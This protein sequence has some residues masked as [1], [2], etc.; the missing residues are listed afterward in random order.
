VEVKQYSI[1]RGTGSLYVTV[2]SSYLQTTLT[3]LSPGTD[4]TFY[5]VAED[6]AGNVS[7]PSVTVSFRTQPRDTTPPSIPAG[8]T[9]T[10]WQT[11]VRL[12]WEPSTDNVGV[13]YYKV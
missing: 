2:G 6:Y 9:A 7:A 8:L 13:S 12:D 11:G 10:R 3:G 5:V 4:Y 1:Y